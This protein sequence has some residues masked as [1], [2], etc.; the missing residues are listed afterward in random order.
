[1]K[2][3]ATS[4]ALLLSITVP[5]LAAPQPAPPALGPALSTSGAKLGPTYFS[6]DNVLQLKTDTPLSEDAWR[7]IEKLQPHFVGTSGKGIDDA[8]VARLSKL[9]LEILYLDGSSM[10]DAGWAALKDLKSLK[11][12]SL[13]HN[14]TW[15]GSGAVALAN[16]SSLTIVGI[17][18]TSFGDVGMPAIASIKQ[19]QSLTLNHARV[20]DT[21]LAALAN[22]PTLEI[23]KYSP[24][25]TPR[26]T[27]ASL[28]T[29]AT[30]KALKELGINDTVLT[31]DGGL[32]LLKGLPNL[33]KVTLDKVGLSEADLAKLKADLP[34]V[35]IKFTPAA[36]DA[37]EKWHQME[38]KL[39][40]GKKI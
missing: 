15:T 34:K 6:K 37:V 16:H 40:A 13:S 21:G 29:V 12:I 22:H 19:L 27:D 20:T 4:L 39:K 10:T 35:D 38:E 24:Q 18:G 28:K 8:A 14:L 11:K 31:Y 33:Q 5:L 2:A 9:P 36:P 26:L 7:E 30:L 1:M 25:M 23:L 32:K 17:G 3:T